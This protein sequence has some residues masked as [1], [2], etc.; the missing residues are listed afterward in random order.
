MADRRPSAPIPPT[1]CK[2]GKAAMPTPQQ[3]ATQ[4]QQGQEAAQHTQSKITTCCSSS[5]T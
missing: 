3:P 4:V 5:D 2:S 1:V